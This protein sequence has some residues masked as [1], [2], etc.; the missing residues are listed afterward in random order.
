MN[1]ADV[2]LVLFKPQVHVF[3]HAVEAAQV[4]GT[5][6]LP[7]T[8]RDLHTQTHTH[9]LSVD[10]V[11]KYLEKTSLIIVKQLVR[12]THVIRTLLWNRDGLYDRLE[13]L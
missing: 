3:A 4:G 1:N 8:L 12:C 6:Q 10:T 2:P 11:S 13:R 7:V 9:M 5:S